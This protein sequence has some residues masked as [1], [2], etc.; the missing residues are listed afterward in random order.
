MWRW[1][2]TLVHL[3][4]QRAKSSLNEEAILK[5]C[6]VRKDSEVQGAI[7][8]MRKQIDEQDSFIK[9]V[10]EYLDLPKEFRLKD[11]EMCFKSKYTS[12]DMNSL[13]H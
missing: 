9:K 5:L 4:V 6:K 2:K 8:N 13:T 3:Q 11:L 1:I 12:K 7:T 10:R